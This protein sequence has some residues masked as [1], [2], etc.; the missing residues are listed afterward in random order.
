[1]S[2]TKRNHIESFDL[3]EV[4]SHFN[5]VSAAFEVRGSVYIDAFVTKVG[6]AFH[7]T[8]HVLTPVAAN[9][10]YNMLTHKLITEIAPPIQVQ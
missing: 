7:M 2:F 9:V 6:T 4:L 5:F 3:T 10:T 1:M 8:T